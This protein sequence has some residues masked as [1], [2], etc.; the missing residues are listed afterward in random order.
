LAGFQTGFLWSEGRFVFGPEADLS[1][2]TL[3]QQTV[4][5]TTIIF[6]GVGSSLLRPTS[7]RIPWLSTLRLKAGFS[8]QDWLF[9]GTGGLAAGEAEMESPLT[10][11]DHAKNSQVLLGYAAGTGVQYALTQNVGIKF[12][13]LYFSLQST[14]FSIAALPGNTP[15][16]SSVS[17]RPSGNI[18]RIGVDWYFH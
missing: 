11:L 18:L 7:A 10:F 1:I 9:Y 2:S 14:N 15:S 13:Y 8:I 17:M 16:F 12:E 6:N 5:K 3:G 4:A